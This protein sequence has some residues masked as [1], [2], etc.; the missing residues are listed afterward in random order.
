M[1]DHNKAV[2]EDSFEWV[3][4]P[5]APSPAPEASN[6]GVRT[7][8]VSARASSNLNWKRTVLIIYLDH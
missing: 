7:T 6:Y 5:K 4:T 3:S 8:S 2:S 1:A